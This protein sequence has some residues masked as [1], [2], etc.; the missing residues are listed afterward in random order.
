MKFITRPR[1]TAFFF[2]L[3]FVIFQAI[4]GTSDTETSSKF[5]R[6][7]ASRYL[8]PRVGDMAVTNGIGSYWGIPVFD[9]TQGFGYRLPTQASLGQSPYIF[10][11]WFA[12]TELIQL[13]YL[14]FAIFL[15]SWTIG[16]YC[17]EHIKNRVQWSILLLH[18]AVLGPLVLFSVV[19]EWQIVAVGFCSRVVLIFFV[20]HQTDLQFNQ[21]SENSRSRWSIAVTTALYLIAVGHP[22]EWT[23]AL[24]PLIMIIF[25]IVWQR[26]LSLAVSFKNYFYTQ[27]TPQLLIGLGAAFVLLLNVS[28]LLIEIGRP[29]SSQ[30]RVAQS[31]G[32][33]FDQ[34]PS[35]SSYSEY[36]KFVE[37]T[38][39][40]GMSVLGP[41]VNI[42]FS[43]NGRYEFSALSILVVVFLDYLICRRSAHEK[44]IRSMNSGLALAF[45]IIGFYLTEIFD[46]I[47]ALLKSSG[48]YQHAPQ[49]LIVSVL[50][51]V[52][53][54]EHRTLILHA[55][56]NRFSK[57][58][59]S[60][61]RK[62]AIFIAILGIVVQPF[63]LL[64]DT[65]PQ[66][67]RNLEAAIREREGTN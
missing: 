27:V 64:K 10:L 47:P 19:N 48:A 30:I 55:K 52:S 37:L 45:L 51:W 67:I 31:T 36:Q 54:R 15:C 60:I 61:I 25:R 29:L 65:S 28:E 39:A 9:A 7:F 23:L 16:N 43:T 11:R 2:S 4:Y 1:N 49:L 18:M 14:G 46:F 34:I 33:T 8:G 63:S 24:P 56:T 44:S 22:G 21:R 20:F 53:D 35:L 58:T 57:K 12:S 13:V 38:V 66:G 50:L 40:F 32:I 6:A 42:F 17:R 3:A 62:F 59:V 5:D 41:I 26:N